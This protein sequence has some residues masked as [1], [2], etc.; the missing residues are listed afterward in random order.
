MGTIVYLQVPQT[1]KKKMRMTILCA[2]ATAAVLIKSINSEITTKKFHSID[3]SPL[4][5]MTEACATLYINYANL[6]DF[7]TVKSP[8]F[9]V[10]DGQ[11]IQSRVFGSVDKKILRFKSRSCRCSAVFHITDRIYDIPVLPNKNS[12]PFAK[13]NMNIVMDTE[14]RFCFTVARTTSLLPVNNILRVHWLSA[15]NMCAH[16]TLPRSFLFL[17]EAQVATESNNKQCSIS[18]AYLNCWYCGLQTKNYAHWELHPFSWSTNRSELTKNIMLVDE[19]VFQNGRNVRWRTIPQLDPMLNNAADPFSRANPGRIMNALVSTI[20]SNFSLRRGTKAQDP[21]VHLYIR[22]WFHLHAPLH[23]VP[24]HQELPWYLITPDSV[25]RSQSSG[26]TLIAP[27]S[28]NMVL[29]LGST[30][31]L[32]LTVTVTIAAFKSAIRFDLWTSIVGVASWMALT[33]VEVPMEVPL[34]KV[35][36]KRLLRF[37]LALWLLL[38]LYVTNIYKSSITSDASYFFPYVSPWHSLWDTQ[39]MTIYFFVNESDC[40]SFM[41]AKE[42][43]TTCLNNSA[44]F[45]FFACL[46]PEVTSFESS[47]CFLHD[48]L[49]HTQM[50][51]GINHWQRLSEL[52]TRLDYVCPSGLDRIIQE[53]EGKRIVF[54]VTEDEFDYYWNIFKGKMQSQKYPRFAYNKESRQDIFSGRISAIVTTG[55]L[56]SGRDEVTGRVRSLLSSGI[57]SLWVRWEAFRFPRKKIPRGSFVKETDESPQ[58]IS[59]ARSDIQL[60]FCFTFGGLGVALLGFMR[61]VTLSSK[62]RSSK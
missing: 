29:L 53:S 44:E 15:C 36:S 52:L 35:H 11:Y 32:T 42:K 40:E 59:L 39:N 23:I 60:I 30:A 5:D 31:V 1:S 9:L 61:E 33:L 54:I 4:Q 55:G 16:G 48:R 38:T 47:R 51:L 27:L 13:V 10:R 6:I 34:R 7:S 18:A 41:K 25:E 20:V 37:M 62:S 58:P 28:I 26:E 12:W 46:Q 43:A 8:A 24:V 57:Y 56:D 49:S 50:R 19:K 45:N 3:I 14:P 17:Y 22:N 2:L 21:R